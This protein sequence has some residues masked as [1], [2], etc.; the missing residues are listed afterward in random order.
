MNVLAGY[1]VM[2]FLDNQGS[3]NCMVRGSSND[4]ATSLI[5]HCAAKEQLAHNVTS[6]YE[7]VHTDDN[8][9][10][11]PSRGLLREAARML[12]RYFGGAFPVEVRQFNLGPLLSTL[13][14]RSYMF[15]PSH[16]G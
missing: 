4:P 11:L 13:L 7:Y 15:P 5:A 14:S 9:A 12:Q 16:P 3:I 1:H 8:L 6:W 2:Y 10:D